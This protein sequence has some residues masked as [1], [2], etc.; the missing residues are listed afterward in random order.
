MR[1]A[2]FIPIKS[3]SERVPGKN[4][5]ILCGKPLYQHIIENALKA[6][7]M[8]EKAFGDFEIDT[9]EKC[10]KK[11]GGKLKSPIYWNK[12]DNHCSFLGPS[13]FFRVNYKHLVGTTEAT[14][15]V[16]RMHGGKASI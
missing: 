14:Q 12:N 8:I 1:V 5:R 6:I 9:I 7:F 16:M 15:K 13:T 4:F 3:N 2:C 11:Y 10:M